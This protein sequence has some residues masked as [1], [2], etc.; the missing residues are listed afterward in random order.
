[1]FSRTVTISY[2]PDSQTINLMNDVA[3]TFK[4]QMQAHREAACLHR[5]IVRLRM[6]VTSGYSF[7]VLSCIGFAL[8]GIDMSTSFVG[9]LCELVV[10][11][12]IRSAACCDI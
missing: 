7:Q 5:C 2:G 4:A 12:V 10:E 11:V 8:Q 3:A 6:S 1:M 9:V